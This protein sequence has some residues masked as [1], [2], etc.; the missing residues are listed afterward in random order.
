M[1]FINLPPW[2]PEHSHARPSPFFFFSCRLL[3]T[4][5]RTA[6]H[7]FSFF[8]SFFPRPLLKVPLKMPRLVSSGRVYGTDCAFLLSCKKAAHTRA[9]QVCSPASADAT[10][11]DKWPTTAVKR[12]GTFNKVENVYPVKRMLGVSHPLSTARCPKRKK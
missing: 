6:W 10:L 11:R 2:Q 5:P 7:L 9:R 3:A 8:L 12:G 4:A 1:Q